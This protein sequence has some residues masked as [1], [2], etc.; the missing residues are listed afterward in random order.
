MEAVSVAM[1]LSPLIRNDHIDPV[2]YVA[3]AADRFRRDIETMVAAA[4]GR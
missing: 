3:A 2:A 4:F 1:D